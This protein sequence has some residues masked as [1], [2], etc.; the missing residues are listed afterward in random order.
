[1]VISATRVM[2]LSFPIR[3]GGREGIRV[4]AIDGETGIAKLHDLNDV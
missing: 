4:L 1:M 2:C 3:N